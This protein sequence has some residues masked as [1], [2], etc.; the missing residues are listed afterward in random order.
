MSRAALAAALALA[1]CA[2]EA[3]EIARACPPQPRG[4]VELAGGAFT[5]G[6]APMHTEEGPPRPASVAPYA[7]DRT[8]VTVADYAAFVEATGYVT[9]AERPPDPARYPGVPV[10]RLKP[11]S[12]VFDP[13]RGEWR[14][15]EGASW[16]RPQG[17]GSSV[18]GR[19]REPVTHVAYA[20]ALAYARWKGRDL[21]TEA[22]WE[23]A[24]RDGLEG[25][26]YAWGDEPRPSGVIPANTWQGL[27]PVADTGE[28]GFKG[29]PAPV[30]CFPAS[31]FGLSDISGNVWE[32]TRAPAGGAPM[33]KGGSYLCADNFCLRYRPAARQEGPPDTGASHIGFRTVRRE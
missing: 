14:V 23:F 13:Q 31:R 7:M 28:D 32:W 24:A 22:E 8:E 2:P 25:A 26:R 21:P 15:V 27:F 17:P 11:S 9:L 6:A 29:R 3:R 20:D 1:G 5:M 33:I 19:E 4:E 16:R 30:G 10:E 12:L 18:A